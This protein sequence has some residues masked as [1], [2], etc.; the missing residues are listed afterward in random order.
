MRQNHRAGEKMFVDYAGQSI[1]V[2]DSFTGQIRQAQI[3]VAVLGASNYTYA[4]ATWSQSLPDWVGS[5]VR[6]FEFFDGVVEVVV[7]DNLKAGVTK[8]CYYEPDI[9]PS[10]QEM[11]THY[12]CA[13]I[14][15]RVRKPRD[16]AKVETAVQVVE[17]WILARLRNVTF[18][19]LDELNA[20]IGKL[21]KNLNGRA[22]K[23]LPGCRQSLYERIDK[24]ALSPLPTQPYVYA[25]WKKARVHIDYHIEVLGHYYSVPYQLLKNQ[26]DVRIT[27]RIVEVFYKGR[28]VASHRRSIQKGYYTTL[29]DHMPKSHQRYAEWTPNRLVRWAEKNGVSTARVV[30]NIL[31]SR[32]HPQQ[33][34]RSCLGI[35]R[36][37]K[38]YGEK[39]LE[40]ACKRAL[41]IG[42][43]S[44][45]SIQA[46]LKTGL[47]QRS[48]LQPCRDSPPVHHDNIRGPQYYSSVKGEQSC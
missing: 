24:P 7:P 10:Y 26:V 12:G 46:I 1:A 47:D 23:K 39:R 35:M 2:V 43:L 19:T 25:E 32:P 44:F 34:F 27:E 16:K 45:K 3:F 31:A 8:A 9:N 37:G 22:F 36:L 20:A 18:F 38:E 15:A 29:R 14:P 11:A 5:H 17:R 48:L 42:G 30:E 28:R 21:I 4:E 13:V 41:A 40:A 6:A 33:G